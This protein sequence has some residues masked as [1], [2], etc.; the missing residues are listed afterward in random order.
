MPPFYLP[1][2][3]RKGSTQPKPLGFLFV[4][5]GSVGVNARLPVRRLLGLPPT[6]LGRNVAQKRHASNAHYDRICPPSAQKIWPFRSRV[7]CCRNLPILTTGTVFAMTKPTSDIMTI[8][9]VAEYL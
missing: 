9:E 7:R 1:E 6:S 3:A 4:S 8:T 2:R 5:S